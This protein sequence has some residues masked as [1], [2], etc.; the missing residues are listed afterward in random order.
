MG[1][2]PTSAGWQAPA[3]LDWRTGNYDLGPADHV[4]LMAHWWER[5]GA[6]PA[7]MWNE[8]IEFHVT[9]PPRDR[10]SELAVAEEHFIYCPDR[11]QEVDSIEAL[12]AELLDAPV[13]HFWWD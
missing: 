2:L 1:L 9:R 13:W 5:Y 7:A 11:L 3:Y 10:A 8:T 12:A 4:R 6:E